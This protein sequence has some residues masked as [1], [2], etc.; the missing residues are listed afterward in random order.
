MLDIA[1]ESYEISIYLSIHWVGVDRTIL[2]E[3]EG[4]E[5][6]VSSLLFSHN[7]CSP[8]IIWHVWSCKRMCY[9]SNVVSRFVKKIT[10]FDVKCHLFFTQ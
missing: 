3:E 8:S 5:D 9:D 10:Y 6:L 2:L 1:E 7:Y 4:V